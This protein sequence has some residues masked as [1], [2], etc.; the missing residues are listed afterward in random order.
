MHCM[1][2]AGTMPERTEEEVAREWIRR[3]IR[4]GVYPS[5]LH[6]M[7]DQVALGELQRARDE[8]RRERHRADA[9]TVERDDLRAEVERLREGLTA[10]NQEQL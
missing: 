7:I 5:T 10:L 6:K 3:R 4:D 2:G 9:A 1:E 8:E